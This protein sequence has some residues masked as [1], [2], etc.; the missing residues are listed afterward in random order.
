M[1]RKFFKTLCLFVRALA[2]GREVREGGEGGE[3]DGGLDAERL[4]SESQTF[5]RVSIDSDQAS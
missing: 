3:Q 5:L 2:R 1:G 4:Y